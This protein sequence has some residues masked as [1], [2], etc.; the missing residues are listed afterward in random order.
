[1][2]IK[3]L[4]DR[5]IKDGNQNTPDA[6][7]FKKDQVVDMSQ[8]SAEHWISRGVAVKVEDTA[9]M[10]TRV[11]RQAAPLSTKQDDTSGDD[12][13]SSVMGS[14]IVGG[15]VTSSTISGAAGGS[16]K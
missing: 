15:V 4:E 2:K 14:T 13:K 16:K 6:E 12:N 9:S 1:M 8:S 7:V 5:E 11:E 10:T 3:F